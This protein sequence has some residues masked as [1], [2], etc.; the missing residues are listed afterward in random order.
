MLLA[1]STQVVGY[2][3][4]SV[5]FCR[6]FVM[7]ILP[8]CSKSSLTYSN[9]P[10]SFSILHLKL[11]DSGHPF[12]TTWDLTALYNPL[13]SH[14]FA[15]NIFYVQKVIPSRLFHSHYIMLS[16][17]MN[18]IMGALIFYITGIKYMPYII[19]DGAL[20]EYAPFLSLFGIRRNS[21]SMT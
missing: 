5:S 16:S 7:S 15:V 10:V 21:R 19:S 13:E 9:T 12:Q 14:C 1:C 6:N 11:N 3:T 17:L 8:P 20:P 2:S 18:K 4:E